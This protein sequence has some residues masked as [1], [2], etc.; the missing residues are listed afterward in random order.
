MR[1]FTN[2][3]IDMQVSIGALIMLIIAGALTGLVPALQAAT[4]N[5]VIAL[6]DE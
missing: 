2:P 1:F 6:K 3:Q 5:P 4:V